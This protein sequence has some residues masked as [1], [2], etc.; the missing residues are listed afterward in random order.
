VPLIKDR[1]RSE[2]W[3]E[4]QQLVDTQKLDVLIIVARR[5]I[6]AMA[7]EFVNGTSA[8]RFQTYEQLE[9]RGTSIGMRYFLILS[10]ACPM[11]M[12]LMVLPN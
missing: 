3:A 9:D 7:R 5:D 10:I 4:H 2:I 12:R 8:L 11:A 1:I 6:N